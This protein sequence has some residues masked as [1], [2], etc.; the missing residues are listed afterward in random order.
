MVA[1][2]VAG[3]PRPATVW[4]RA[5]P[6]T[7]AGVRV[8]AAVVIDCRRDPGCACQ[9]SHGLKSL[10]LRKVQWLHC[11]PGTEPGTS[12]AR[13]HYQAVTYRGAPG[14][15]WSAGGD[16]LMQAPSSASA[17]RARRRAGSAEHK[18]APT[19]SAEAERSRARRTC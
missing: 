12:R 11:W 3:T 5:A 7:F 2:Q 8:G 14:W 6:A 9:L 10:P 19:T 1:R 13:Y 15:V 17:Q 4:N 16:R 18:H